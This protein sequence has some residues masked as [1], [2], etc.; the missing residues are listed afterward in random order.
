MERTDAAVTDAEKIKREFRFLHNLFQHYQTLKT[1][2]IH[3][4]QLSMGMSGDYLL[5]IEAGSTMVRIGSLLFGAREA[6]KK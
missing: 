5:A 2:N 1:S 3:F 6:P 4:T